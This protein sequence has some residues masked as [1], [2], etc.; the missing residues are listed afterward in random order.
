[1]VRQVAE[2]LEGVLERHDP[3]EP[4]SLSDNQVLAIV[5]RDSGEVWVGTERGGL[6]K[7]NPVGGERFRPGIE[8]IEAAAGADPDAAVGVRGE[9]VDRLAPRPV[10]VAREA[11]GGEVEAVESAF[12]AD[13]QRPVSANVEGVDGVVGETSALT[14]TI[15]TEG[16]SNA[17]PVSGR[18]A[19]RASRSEASVGRERRAWRRARAAPPP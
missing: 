7:Y 18:A 19:R 3:N 17:A 10:A 12:G 1:M 11:T 14:S 15:R 13:P 16:R 2:G 6:N 4:R 8:S 5:A 9:R